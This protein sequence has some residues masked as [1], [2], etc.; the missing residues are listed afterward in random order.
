[1]ASVDPIQEAFTQAKQA[2]Y[3]KIKDRG[4]YKEIL[5]TTTMDDVYKTATKLQEEVSA[6]N[7]GLRYLKKIEPFLSRLKSFDSVIDTGVSAKPEVLALIWGPLKLLLI[8]SC[9]LN[10]ARDKIADTLVK[11]AYTLPQF[12]VVV[13]VFEDYEMVKTALALVYEDILDFYR[14]SF[15]FFHIKMWK[16]LFKPLWPSHETKIDLVIENLKKHSDLLRDEVTVLDIK[17]AREARARSFEHFDKT[18][19]FQE[20]Q[21]FE[22]LRARI[23]P[24]TYDGR[25]DWLRNRSVAGCAKWL[26]RDKEFCEWLDFSK[27]TATWFWLHGIPG[28]G[29]TYLCAAVLDHVRKQHRTLFAFVSH[30]EPKSHMAISLF[31]SFIFQAADEDDKFQQLLLESKERELR[32]NTAHAS[33]LLKTFLQTN[34]HTYIIIDGIDEMEGGERHILLHRLNEL[35]K[36][37][38]DVRVLISSRTEDDITRWI[39]P[40]ATGIRVDH[41][42]SGSIQKYV[43]QRSQTWLAKYYPDS[44]ADSDIN[45]LLYPLSA[46]AEGE[47]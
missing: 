27:K 6:K 15:D 4:Q 12:D 34:G 21:K 44:N 17:E 18:K 9:E 10:A 3:N 45:G 11:I 23:L 26:F 41:R 33:E 36:D 8:W 24:S 37:C 16:E 43:D 20:R 47:P 14:V 13:Q 2:F 35:S 19:T 25:L 46:N 42:N 7:R 30:T 22:I 1:M 40:K 39:E 5:T 31:H 29:K 38:D 28:A 32:G